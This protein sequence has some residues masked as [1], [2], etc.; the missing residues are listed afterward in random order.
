[1]IRLTSF[2]TLTNRELTRRLTRFLGRLRY[3]VRCEYLLVNEWR[4][5]QRHAHLL[6][7]A[8]GEITPELVS[9]LWAKVIPGPTSIRSSY[10]RPVR[11]PIAVARYVV[12]HVLDEAKKEVAP[13]TY[14]GRVM[15]YSKGFLSQSLDTLWREQLRDWNVRRGPQGTIPAQR[16]E[17]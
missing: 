4:G 16:E 13:R 10:C 3:R 1:M 9:A 17:E 5:E 2:A 11:N 12:K 15:T 7:R 8:S 6:I 14:P